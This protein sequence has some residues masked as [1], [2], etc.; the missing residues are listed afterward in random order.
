M[1]GNGFRRNGTREP[2]FLVLN[3]FGVDVTG[4]TVSNNA[5]GILIQ[6]DTTTSRGIVDDVVISGNTVTMGAGQRSGIGQEQYRQIGSVVFSGTTYIHSEASPFVL[7]GRVQTP[8][9]WRALGFDTAGQFSK[10]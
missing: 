2:G 10:V 8:T 4:N 3:S 9:W 7:D 5:L 1:T 6:Q